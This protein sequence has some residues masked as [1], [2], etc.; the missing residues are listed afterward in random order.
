PF[1]PVPRP[2]PAN[3]SLPRRFPPVWKALPRRAPPRRSMPLPSS[4]RSLNSWSLF[5]IA[6]GEPAPLCDRSL[7]NLLHFSFL[8]QV[9]VDLRDRCR[10]QGLF[11]RFALNLPRA[12]S[13]FSDQSTKR[14]HKE[15]SCTSPHNPVHIPPQTHSGS[16]IS[17]S[18]HVLL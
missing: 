4:V 1:A 11:V 8:G 12:S 18:L 5:I 6:G 15:G 16:R 14:Q 7:S 13:S 2:D 9:L 10:R 3:Y 17:R